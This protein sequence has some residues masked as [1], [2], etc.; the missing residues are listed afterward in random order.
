MEEIRVQPL[1]SWESHVKPFTI[2][3]K[4]MGSKPFIQKIGWQV[5]LIGLTSLATAFL[6]FGSNRPLVF[7]PLL[8]LIFLLIKLFR[9]LQR[10]N[11]DIALFFE[12]LMND[13]SS[14]NLEL[15]TA[16]P[17]SINRSTISS[18][19]KQLFT[20]FRPKVIRFHYKS[21]RVFSISVKKGIVYSP[22]R[23]LKPN[24]MKKRWKR[25]KIFSGYCRMK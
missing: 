22:F 10:T 12:G 6:W 5:V 13:D 1:S 25:G 8:L 3:Q 2:R 20:N 15:K 11:K 19:E 14:I 24:L 18:R 21:G 16:P 4:N 9:F 23:I 7:I 17:R